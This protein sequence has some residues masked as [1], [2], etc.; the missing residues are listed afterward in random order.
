M[1]R[2][3][4][5]TGKSCRLKCTESQ[6]QAKRHQVVGPGSWSVGMGGASS[7]APYLEGNEICNVERKTKE[8]LGLRETKP[9]KGRG[10]A[11]VSGV[12]GKDFS[13][14]KQGGVLTTTVYSGMTVYDTG[15]LFIH[16]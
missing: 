16:V 4:C 10:R 14:K 12:G 6:V 13:P 8:K 11:V 15:M 9:R 1:I 3:V 7:R 2:V 5:C